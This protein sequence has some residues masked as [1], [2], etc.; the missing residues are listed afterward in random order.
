MTE[1]Q[2]QIYYVVLLG[3][4]CVVIPVC[5]AVLCVVMLHRRA[6]WYAYPAYFVLFGTVGGWCLTFGLS[7]SPLAAMC[8]MFMVLTSPVCLLCS[9]YLQGRKD[10]DKFGSAAM[11]GG[12]S[13]SGLLG[14]AVISLIVIGTL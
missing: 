6:R 13:Y 5:F 3:P 9:L 12:Y 4:A 2:T 7:P 11:I 10:L 1:A 14:I 8:V